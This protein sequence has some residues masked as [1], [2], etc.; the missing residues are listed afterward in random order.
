MSKVRTQK[1]RGTKGKKVTVGQ[2]QKLD[3]S[4]PHVGVYHGGALTDLR[5]KTLYDAVIEMQKH[6]RLI[7]RYSG[8][9]K[10][11]DFNRS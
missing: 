3:A 6:R 11:S 4:R 8:K 2:Q 10:P 7:K 9:A 5:R 1:E